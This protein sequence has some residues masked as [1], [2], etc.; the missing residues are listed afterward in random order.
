MK[1]VP[2]ISQCNEVCFGVLQET[3]CK[4]LNVEILCLLVVL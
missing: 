1:D 4:A 2:S 3:E